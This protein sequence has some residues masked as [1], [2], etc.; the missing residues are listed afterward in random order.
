M[1]APKDKHFFSISVSF[2]PYIASA[3]FL[4][5]LG[6]FTVRQSII[7]SQ[8]AITQSEAPESSSSQTSFIPLPSP[9]TRS[10]SSLESSLNNRRTRR[11]FMDKSITEKQISQVLWAGQ[12]VVTEWGERTTPS[13]KSVYPNTIYLLSYNI[14]KIDTG[15]YR[16]MP[17]D[18]QPLHQLEPKKIGN[19]KDE[20]FS[21][22]N[23][24]TLKQVPAV[25]IIAANFNKMNKAYM[26]NKQSPI[27][28][29][30][31]GNII[32]NINLQLENLKLGTLTITSFDQTKLHDI[33]GLPEDETVIALLPI[34]V[35]KE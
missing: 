28:Y 27:V 19:F 21:I 9:D 11:S 16:Y 12:G 8:P 18:R 15:L 3:L 25:I 1:S 23:Q 29:M 31:A 7:S 30:E 24:S 22:T 32:Q 14:E 35:P 4:I 6:I 13:S 34:G 5:G 17:G 26:N 2:I 10:N 33:L 20:V